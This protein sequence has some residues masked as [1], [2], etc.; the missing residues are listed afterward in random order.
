LR[1]EV[2]K[3]ERLELIL[4]ELKEAS[5]F[6]SGENARERLYEIMTKV[7]DELSGIPENPAAASSAADGRM[8]PPDDNFE[9]ASGSPHVRTFK[10]LRH[11]TSFGDNGAVQITRPD[12]SVVFDIAGA[13][14]RFVA[15]LIL[16]R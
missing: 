12:A 15:D 4:R 10:Q 1:I 7:E 2:P 11:R 13:D 9:I 16:E 8:Y 3:A 5:P 14:G 6:S